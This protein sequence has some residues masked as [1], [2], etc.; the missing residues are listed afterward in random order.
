MKNCRHGLCDAHRH[1][2]LIY[3]HEELE[4]KEGSRRFI[5]KEQLKKHERASMTL[6]LLHIGKAPNHRQSQKGNEE[7]RTFAACLR[8]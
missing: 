8:E 6:R 7:S 2:E 4:R 1:R 5:G 3:F